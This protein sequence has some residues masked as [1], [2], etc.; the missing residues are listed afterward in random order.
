MQTAANISILLFDPIF[1]L[2]ET[3]N[4]VKLDNF[5]VFEKP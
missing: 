4:K 3:R 2:I 1:S 5:G